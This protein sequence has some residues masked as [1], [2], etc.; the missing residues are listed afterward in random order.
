MCPH[1][2]TEGRGIS[3]VQKSVGEFSSSGRLKNQ[4]GMEMSFVSLGENCNNKL[5]TSLFFLRTN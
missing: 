2:G 4:N 1:T 5:D 3:D